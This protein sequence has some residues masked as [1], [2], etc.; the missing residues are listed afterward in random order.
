MRSVSW[1]SR[2]GMRV[3]LVSEWEIAR[4]IVERRCAIVAVYSLMSNLGCVMAS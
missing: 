4:L 3:E 1:V 2:L